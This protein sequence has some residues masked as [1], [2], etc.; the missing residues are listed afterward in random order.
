MPGTRPRIPKRKAQNSLGD[1]KANGSVK[2]QRTT[3]DAFFA[4]RQPVS[5]IESG[6]KTTAKDPLTKGP[7]DQGTSGRR[8]DVGLSAEQ[9][10]VLRMVV[11]DERNI[12]FTGSAG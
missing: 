5:S 7:K 1:P 2:L 8:G 9:A 4:P 11:D 3:L 12:F 6:E 10:K